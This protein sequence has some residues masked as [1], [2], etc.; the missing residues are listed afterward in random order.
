[1]GSSVSSHRPP[2]TLF[3]ILVVLFSLGLV[4]SGKEQQ[5][6]SN[7]AVL[8][9]SS[10]SWR[11]YRH[12]SN[13]LSI[14]RTVK[15]LG[16]PDS[17]ILLFLA[18]DHACN[19]RNPWKANMFKSDDHA[20]NVYGD[21]VEVDYRGYEVTVE[22]LLRVLTGN[23]TGRLQARKLTLYTHTH[24]HTHTH[25]HTHTHTYTQTRHHDSYCTQAGTTQLC[26]N[27]RGCCLTGEATYW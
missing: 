21:D 23:V 12:S 2:Q 6:N 7:F 8:V 17:N 14:Y 19:P 1:M 10:R 18:D 13:L 9:S 5:H 26:Q 20:L 27:P 15:R 25:I 11:N 4:V 24:T 3:A 16:I 22:N